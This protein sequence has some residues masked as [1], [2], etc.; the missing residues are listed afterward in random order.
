[1]SS[2]ARRWTSTK[3]NIQTGDGCAEGICGWGNS[4][5]QIYTDSNYR[6]ENGSLIIEARQESR[7]HTDLARD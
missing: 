6:V 3:W 7:R 5:Q 4:E 1:M 2:T